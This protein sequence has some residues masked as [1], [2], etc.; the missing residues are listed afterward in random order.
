MAIDV[1]IQGLGDASASVSRLIGRTVFS[2]S[3][4]DQALLDRLFQARD[5]INGTAQ[6]T[7]AADLGTTIAD[8]KD[9]LR[10]LSDGTDALKGVASAVTS[11]DKV[12]GIVNQIADAAS[13]VLAK[14][15]A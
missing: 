6:R 15:I 12:L 2:D 9:E 11:T 7:I 13:S 3:P 10:A 5:E 8:F 1:V 4:E 14:V